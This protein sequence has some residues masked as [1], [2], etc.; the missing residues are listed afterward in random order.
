MSFCRFIYYKQAWANCSFVLNDLNETRQQMR[1]KQGK[2]SAGTVFTKVRNLLVRCLIMWHLV[3]VYLIMWHLVVLRLIMWRSVAWRL[4]MWRSVSW[5]LITW[6]SV[7]WRCVVVSFSLEIDATQL[8]TSDNLPPPS[9][10]FFKSWTPAAK[11]VANLL[12]PLFAVTKQQ[13][14]SSQQ[15]VAVGCFLPDE[16]RYVC[17]SNGFWSNDGSSI[18]GLSNNSSSNNK[19]LNQQYE[20]WR[21]VRM[22]IHQATTISLSTIRQM[23][24]YQ[25]TSHRMIFCQML[26]HQTYICRM[27]IY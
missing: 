13:Q 21:Q 12:F 16:R 19:W 22:T 6:R 14:F 5:R 26:I 10:E 18:N 2:V 17:L 9:K 7:A 11:K 1:Q 24:I 8:L 3:V 25:M 15:V 23:K 27:T 4:I 20:K